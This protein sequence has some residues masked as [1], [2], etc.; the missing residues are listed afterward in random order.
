MHEWEIEDGVVLTSNPPRRRI[1]CT[2]CGK[3]SSVEQGKGLPEEEC[4][5]DWIYPSDIPEKIEDDPVNHPKH[6]TNGKVE[7]IDWIE[8]MLSPEEFRG[9]LKGNALK[10][11]WRYKDKGH[12]ETDLGKARWYIEK[13][14]SKER[15]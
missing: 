5:A 6:Y 3:V 8:E 13:L 7:C 2:K 15:M 4:P 11:L 9:Y 12:P 14:I 10:Y 1:R